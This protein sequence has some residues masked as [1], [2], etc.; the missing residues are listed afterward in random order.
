M[1]LTLD[2]QNHSIAKILP[3][4]QYLKSLDHI[5]IE[6][7][8]EENNYLSNEQQKMLDQRLETKP[9]DYLSWEDVKKNLKY[10]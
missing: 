5:K 9:E 2:I 6:E 7:T 8:T 1:R 4:I 3:L 10:K